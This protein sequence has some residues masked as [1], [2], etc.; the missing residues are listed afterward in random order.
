M[1][2]RD[3]MYFS[4]ISVM[5]LARLSGIHQT[6]ISH[7]RAENRIPSDDQKRKLEKILSTPIEWPETKK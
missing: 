2:L 6:Y 1:K 3:A 5:R 7:F 4:N